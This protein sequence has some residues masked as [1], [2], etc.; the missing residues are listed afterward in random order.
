MTEGPV[1]S[2]RVYR[3]AQLDRVLNPQSIAIVGASPRAGS[4]GERL[5]KNLAG[6]QGRLYLVNAK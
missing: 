1:S 3:H 6:F 5:Q 4:F 2:R